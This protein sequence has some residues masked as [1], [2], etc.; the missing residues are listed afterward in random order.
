MIEELKKKSFK[1][2][3]PL[4]IILIIAG[5]VLAVW[6]LNSAFYALTGLAKFEDLDPDEIKNQ[7][8][9]ANLNIVYDCYLETGTENTSTHSKTINYYW[10]IIAT[11]DEYAL[12]YKWMAIKVPKK[13]RGQ[14]DDIMDY[15]YDYSLPAP[16]PLKIEGK[17]KKLSDKYYNYFR[18]YFIDDCEFSEADFEENTLPYYIDVNLSM[19]T[20]KYGYVFLVLAGLGLVLWGILRIVKGASGNFLKDFTKDYQSIGLTE[21]SVESDMAAAASF[22]KHGDVKVGR[23]CTY[24]GLNGT[25]PRAIPNSKILWCYQSTTTHRTNGVKTGV[26]YSIMVFVEGVKNAYNIG[27]PNELTAQDV[28][29]RIGETLPWVV[30]GYSE[31]LRRM[32]NKDHAAFLQLRYNTVEHVAV[33][34]GFEGFRSETT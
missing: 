14:V 32:F 31:E 13:I 8:V 33:D 30:V 12:D 1:K 6:N 24:Y 34:P 10:Y 4:S 7:L 9:E 26:T 3:L 25:L 15:F 21:S 22:T 23:I 19:S 2:S 17:I 27:V 20:L 5:L 11:G 28:L 16:D 29:K 18:D